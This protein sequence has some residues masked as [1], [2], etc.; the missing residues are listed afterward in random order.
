[1]TDNI[2]D[3]LTLVINKTFPM[4]LRNTKDQSDNP[5]L[6]YSYDSSTRKLVV[7]VPDNKALELIFYAQLSGEAGKNVSVNNTV[8]LSG[9][10]TY[11]ETDTDSKVVS[12]GSIFSWIK[13]G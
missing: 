6:D 10:A 4:T 5:A 11:I 1:M 2:P 8:N 12:G 13:R 3:N 9:S 7:N